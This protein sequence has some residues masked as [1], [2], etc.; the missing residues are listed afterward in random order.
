MNY[1]LNRLGEA[2]T[3]QGIV[4][5]LGVCGVKL[6]PEESGAIVTACVS[7]VAAISIFTKH[8]ASPDAQK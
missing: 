2:S 7:I 5:I 1:V 3:W 4:M 8:P 6:S